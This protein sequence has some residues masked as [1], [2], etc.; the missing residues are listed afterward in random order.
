M[1]T[2]RTPEAK[3]NFGKAVEEMRKMKFKCANCNEEEVEHKGEWCDSCND[4]SDIPL[5]VPTITPEE[6][7]KRISKNQKYEEEFCL[8]DYIY[9]SN[10]RDVIREDKVKYFIKIIKIRLKYECSNKGFEIIDKLSGEKLT[11]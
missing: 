8:E 7:I 5:K 10:E 9:E 4:P 2:Q 6:L 3:Y 1:T 11:K